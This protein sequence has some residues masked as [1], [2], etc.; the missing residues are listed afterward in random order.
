ME[1]ASGLWPKANRLDPH[2]SKSTW[3]ITCLP[4]RSPQRLLVALAVVLAFPPRPAVVGM[5]P[6]RLIT[7]EQMN[8]DNSR[9]RPTGEMTTL[10]YAKQ[11]EWWMEL[12]S[13]ECLATRALH[14]RDG[15]M[16]ILQFPNQCNDLNL[17]GDSSLRGCDCDSIT[18]SR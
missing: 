1:L 15:V 3:T 12:T 6:K 8:L 2:K 16:H 10:R 7:T 17:P 4:S 5:I 14:F 13:E 11:T 9:F 18:M